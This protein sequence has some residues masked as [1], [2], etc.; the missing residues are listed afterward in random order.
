MTSAA[1]PEK[2]YEL[3]ERIAVGGMAEVFRAKA[4]GPHGFEKVLAIKRILPALAA[5]PKF[6]R[7]FVTEAKV[8]VS[9]GHA[10]IV[11]VFDFSR[12][13]QSLYIV[14]E[15]IDG[16][17]LAHVMQLVREKQAPVPIEAAMHVAV[18]LLKGLDFAHRREVVHRD[19]SPSNILLSRS[20]EVKIADFGIAQMGG[21]EASRTLKI[22]GKWRYMSPEQSRGDDVDA[23]SDVF[24]AGS[25][26]F[27]LF[28][29]QKLFPGS[30]ARE[31]VDNIHG[32]ELP[33][34]SSVRPDLPP[35]L[36]DALLSVLE[37]DRE[38]RVTA[39]ELLQ[40]ILEVCYAQSI[41]A[42][43]T[44]LARFLEE[45]EPGGLRPPDATDSGPAKLLD[46]I[47]VSELGG[48]RAETRRARPPDVR[49]TAMALAPPPV[50]PEDAPQESVDAPVEGGDLTQ[51]TFIRSVP[52]PG[53][54]NTWEIEEGTPFPEPVARAAQPSEVNTV[55]MRAPPP[56]SATYPPV[57][58]RAGT[59][60]ITG[61]MPPSAPEFG[62]SVTDYVWSGSQKKAGRLV[63]ILIGVGV[64]VLT[65]IIALASSG[66]GDARKKPV[67]AVIADAAPV[68]VPAPDPVP[69]PAATVD[70][71]TP[72]AAPPTE[73]APDAG[74]RH[75]GTPRPPRYGTVDIYSEP[76]ANIYLGKRKVG[77]APQRGVKLPV[78]RHKLRLVNPVQKRSMTVTVTV[79]SPRPV[80][81]TLPDRR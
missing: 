80:R 77:V 26:L 11:Q 70:A 54:P 56:R 62:P 68:A 64:A 45:L 16:G 8:A 50:M 34:A 4:Y 43:P 13:G 65:V 79:P 46:Q 72:D 51:V 63:P 73:A 53:G 78:G 41:P 52:Q 81:V 76:W 31:I 15:F 66:G 57:T 23:R 6:E 25:V 55:A 38:R 69:V 14:M 39:A 58:P 19:L 17:D 44:T 75:T 60:P 20:G 42:L 61:S 40:K 49:R 67:A 10:N 59:G 9:L 3:V 37:R 29:G 71:G 1:Q 30:D 74:P 28:T 48:K 47:L 36:D 7:R 35:A 32:M 2:R 21:G 33:R 18:E 22:M 27:E 5:D 12:F 24:S